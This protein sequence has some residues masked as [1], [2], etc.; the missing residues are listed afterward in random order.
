MKLA[1]LYSGAIRTLSET[2]NN[3]LDFFND[4]DIDLYFSVWEHVG[5]SPRI[6]SPDYKMCGKRLPH[7]TRVN[8][9]LIRNLV[10]NKAIIKKIK[11]EN[12]NSSNYVLNLFNGIDNSGLPSQY[13]KI[14]DCFNLI[15]KTRYDA[16]VRLRCD[17]L[18]QNK[19]SATDIVSKVRSNKIIFPENIWYQ[20]KKT[21]SIKD[22]N[23]M[24]WISNFSN[25][26]KACAIYNNSCKINKVIMENSYKETNYGERITHM[27]LEAENLVDNIE[28]HDFDYLVLR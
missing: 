21:K 10:G 12:Y 6:N 24:I 16:I 28:T 3:N 27:N 11:I 23:E 4:F 7:D 22:I 9:E 15:D 19:I 13:Y 17:L 25:M 14:N 2:I 18:L 1:I 20:H 26:K 5:Y 8:E